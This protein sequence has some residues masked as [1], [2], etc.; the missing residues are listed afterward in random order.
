M[1]GGLTIL[2]GPLV[3]G[4]SSGIR[5]FQSYRSGG[6]AVDVPASTAPPASAQLAPAS[7][8]LASA[9]N[10]AGSSFGSSFGQALGGGLAK[11]IGYALG[12]IVLLYFLAN[13]LPFIIAKAALKGGR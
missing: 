5:F 12:A 2:G 6:K 7:G 10:Q 9:A 8:P 13:V 11:P 4:V 1:R 3:Q